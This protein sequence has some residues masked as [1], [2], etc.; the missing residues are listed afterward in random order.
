MLILFQCYFLFPSSLVNVFKIVTP[1]LVLIAC[2]LENRLRISNNLFLFWAGCF[3]LICTLSLIYA[4][5]TVNMLETYRSLGFCFIMLFAVSQYIKEEKDIETVIHFMAIGGVLYALYIFINQYDTIFTQSIDPKYTNQTI[6]Q[7][8]YI[9]I[10]TVYY[11]SY[12]L[13]NNKGNRIFSFVLVAFSY[14][15]CIVSGRRK[16]FFLPLLF[17]GMLFVQK[18]IKQKLKLLIAI[19]ISL[20]LMYGIYYLCMNNE[21]LYNLIGYRINRLILFFSGDDSAD[22]SAWARQYLSITSW[23]LFKQNP[24]F[25]IGLGNFIY[26]NNLG[27][28]AHNNYLELLCDLG[29]IGTVAFYWIYIFLIFKLITIPDYWSDGL[30]QLILSLLLINLVMDFG[31]ITYYRFYFDIIIC[32]ALSYVNLRSKKMVFNNKS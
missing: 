29:L 25:G 15:M 31:T 20:L 7:F 19:I 16:A 27:Y 2:L 11:L 13:F 8:T 32:L 17:I 30:A 6:M 12:K 9:M 23:D 18:S 26:H 4:D 1:I 24:F 5:W 10:P 22:S 3:F 14:L 21:M 28:Y